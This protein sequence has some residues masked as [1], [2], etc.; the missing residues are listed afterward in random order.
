MPVADA[1]VFI[2]GRRTPFDS[3]LTVPEVMEELE[4]DEAQRKFDFADI[5][6]REPSED[7]LSKI[8]EKSDELN[9]P[10]SEV[11]EKLLALALETGQTLV[12]DDKALQNLS[13]HLGVSF[14]SYMTDRIE[15]KKHWEEYCPNCGREVEGHCDRCGRETTRRLV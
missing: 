7:V 4:S 9:S 1:N 11:D 8:K 12:T 2:R 6:V 15:K 14:E 13:L 3:A 5:S 10:T